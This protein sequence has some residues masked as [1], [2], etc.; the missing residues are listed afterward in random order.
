MV[1]RAPFVATIGGK[2]ITIGGAMSPM[3]KTI[4]PKLEEVA[5]AAKGVKSLS[6]KIVGEL[7]AIEKKVESA[8]QVVSKNYGEMASQ[9]N[10][11]DQSSTQFKGVLGTMLKAD[12]IDASA[13][14]SGLSPATKQEL[15]DKAKEL[16]DKAKASEAA[17]EKRSMMYYKG[18][19]DAVSEHEKAMRIFDEAIKDLTKLKGELGKLS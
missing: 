4:V 2:R 16:M 13:K 10:N 17:I 8:A 19:M 9:V 1:E 14:K 18:F 6:N 7:K 11:L 15:M 3:Y 12:E 5:D